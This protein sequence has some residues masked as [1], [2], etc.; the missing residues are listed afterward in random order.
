MGARG[1]GRTNR[2]APLP[3][4]FCNLKLTGPALAPPG[5]LSSL[6]AWLSSVVLWG[7]KAA[8]TAWPGTVPAAWFIRARSMRAPMACPAMAVAMVNKMT[9]LG[10]MTALRSIATKGMLACTAIHQEAENFSVCSRHMPVGMLTAVAVR[11]TARSFKGSAWGRSCLMGWVAASM[12]RA[13]MMAS[14]HWMWPCGV[15]TRGA[16]GPRNLRTGHRLPPASA[17]MCALVVVDRG[18]R[19][20]LPLARV[21]GG[22][23]LRG[24][25]AGGLRAWCCSCRARNHLPTSGMLPKADSESVARGRGLP[26][27]ASMGPTGVRWATTGT[28]WVGAGWARTPGVPWSCL[29]RGTTPWEPWKAENVEAYDSRSSRIGLR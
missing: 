3:C 14:G 9:N 16:R 11:P 17:G 23:S 19:V 10:M 25:L 1:R 22:S 2:L 21:E 27:R 18:R 26:P 20:L 7:V 13:L 15:K 29:G 4:A 5:R 6:T 8:T 28:A 12:A 24:L